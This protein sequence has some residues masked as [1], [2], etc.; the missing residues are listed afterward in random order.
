MRS[1]NLL[2]NMKV[3]VKYCGHCNPLIDGPAIMAAVKEQLDNVQFV[4]SKDDQGDVLLIIS[5]CPVD[6]AERPPH[7]GPEIVIAG[8]A[9]DGVSVAQRDL[10]GELVKKILRKMSSEK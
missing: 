6:C 8:P 1:A 9:I 10:P 5:G 4:N 7:T 2:F 3:A